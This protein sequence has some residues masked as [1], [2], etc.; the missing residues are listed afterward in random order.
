MVARFVEALWQ[1][2]GSEERTV[3]PAVTRHAVHPARTVRSIRHR[4]D[5]LTRVLRDMH[6]ALGA[7]DGDVF[8]CSC[9]RLIPMLRRH[10]ARAEVLLYSVGPVVC[11]H[12]LVVC[13]DELL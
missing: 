13:L 8:I 6:A 2:L 10:I 4:H 12:P 11:G 1:R 9:E 3:V 5:Q 7:Q